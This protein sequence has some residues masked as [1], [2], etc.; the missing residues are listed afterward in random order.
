M[1]IT[2]TVGNRADLR[3]DGSVLKLVA[4]AGQAPPSAANRVAITTG[5]NVGIRTTTP[6]S[7]R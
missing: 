5:G 4:T 1:S 6:V 3:F 7:V 2:P